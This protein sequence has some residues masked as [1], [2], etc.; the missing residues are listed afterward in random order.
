MDLKLE[1]VLVWKAKI[2]KDISIDMHQD[3][4][5]SQND[6]LVKKFSIQCSN[7]GQ[8]NCRLMFCIKKPNNGFFV[9]C[10]LVYPD[11]MCQLAQ[12]LSNSKLEFEKN[13]T[14][15][16]HLFSMEDLK[17]MEKK[18]PKFQS[19]LIVEIPPETFRT[20]EIIH[21]SNCEIVKNST[22]YI[23]LI[24]I[25]NKVR[26]ANCLSMIDIILTFKNE[27]TAKETLIYDPPT[28]KDFVL[29]S[30]KI[31]NDGQRMFSKIS[32]KDDSEK[33]SENRY[34]EYLAELLNKKYEEIS[35][36]KNSRA[37]I[38]IPYVEPG[39]KVS[40]C[41]TYSNLMNMVTKDNMNSFYL[42][43][44]HMFFKHKHSNLKKFLSEVKLSCSSSIKD[45]KVSWDHE[46]LA[47]SESSEKEELFFSL[48][49]APTKFTEFQTKFSSAIFNRSTVLI[50]KYQD[51]HAG[52]VFFDPNLEIEE[53]PITREYIFV[54][55]RSGS[56]WGEK[57]A[58]A[59]RA[60]KL[61]L[62]SLGENSTFNIVSF[63]SNAVL[64][65]PDG[66]LSYNDKNKTMAFDALDTFTADMEG[67]NIFSALTIIY[68]QKIKPDTLRFIFF[69]TD[70]EDSTKDQSLKLIEDNK[71]KTRVCTIGIFA[72]SES[73]QFLEGAA[74]NGNG[75]CMNIE[76]IEDI[77]KKLIDQL[78]FFEKKEINELKINLTNDYYDCVPPNLS[79]QITDYKEHT[80]YFVCKE[81]NKQVKI[82]FK[83]EYL[84]KDRTLSPFILK[85]KE[86]VRLDKIF[87]EK[88]I[89]YLEEC[90]KS[91][92]IPKSNVKN[93][94]GNLFNLKNIPIT[95]KKKL[96]NEIK[97]CSEKYQVTSKRTNLDFEIKSITKDKNSEHKEPMNEVQENLS[98]FRQ[99][100]TKLPK[101]GF[102]KK[103]DEVKIE[104]AKMAE[105]PSK[106]I[107]AK[108]VYKKDFSNKA[109]INQS[110]KLNKK[111]EEEKKE[112]YESDN[113]TG[114]ESVGNKEAKENEKIDSS[115][116]N[117]ESE[118]S[119][120]SEESENS[121]E[122]LE[123][124]KEE[125]AP[126][127]KLV[128]ELPEEYKLLTRKVLQITEQLDEVL[129]LFGKSSYVLWKDTIILFPALLL[130]TSRLPKFSITK[131]MTATIFILG[132]FEIQYPELQAEWQKEYDLGIDWLKYHKFIYSSNHETITEIIT[133]IYSTTTYFPDLRSENLIIKSNFEL[134]LLLLKLHNGLY[135]SYHIISTILPSIEKFKFNIDYENLNI[136]STVYILA[137]LKK[138][139]AEFECD[140]KFMYFLSKKWLESFFID[141]DKEISWIVGVSYIE[142][143]KEKNEIGLEGEFSETNFNQIIKIFHTEGYWD[144][145]KTNEK[146]SQLA[147]LLIM[148]KDNF[149]EDVL[150]TLFIVNI[151]ETK[152]SDKE[153][154]WRI[155]KKKAENWLKKENAQLKESENLFEGF[156]SVFSYR[157]IQSQLVLNRYWHFILI[158][159][160]SNG[161]YWE[162]NVGSQLFSSLGLYYYA[163]CQGLD[164]DIFTTVVFIKY[165]EEYYSEELLEWIGF[166]KK[167]IKWLKTEKGINYQVIKFEFNCPE[168]L[169]VP[170]MIS[171]NEALLSSEAI[172]AKI[173]FDHCKY[174]YATIIISDCSTYFEVITI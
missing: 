31:N 25:K 26:I 113:F 21:A 7:S 140:W 134:I 81:F 143:G 17:K 57:L 173:M 61:C 159:S 10:G 11:K 166:I 136:K 43:Y 87:G 5:K 55:D 76:K 66:S 46:M 99:L 146:F 122:S 161:V 58:L 16:Q 8:I 124:N 114:N 164:Q 12:V 157:L 98:I 63:G 1:D 51:M 149:K 15:C 125:E 100:L 28:N 105:E 20:I 3:A 24:K 72:S 101:S 104:E 145:Q 60:L 108:I 77:S 112:T 53:K 171:I 116:S 167:A 67:T 103:S 109:I 93:A 128:K 68:E 95:D 40:I 29:V 169:R 123:I 32:S 27:S 49:K 37:K 75:I 48:K 59:S 23:S 160:V 91:I 119:D 47:K 135:W 130:F 151:L 41:F 138:F 84:K 131:D 90:I 142:M 64:F 38:C 162:F 14:G 126:Q 18:Q 170:N 102:A 9:A 83:D 39:K 94:S 158:L 30:I 153:F 96:I 172:T 118:S 56:M 6:Y 73:M 69:I 65:A 133:S 132:L 86:D 4:P 155:I 156:R 44:S 82:T 152:Y 89:Q 79:K 121:E 129:K 168:I 22:P 74:K 106:S 163:K 34:K 42:S 35:H 165:L 174:E 115:E 71:I 80:I 70:G 52:I 141:A 36:M 13:K 97:L 88:K 110:K 50:Q 85:I 19:V 78:D 120:E 150:A 54:L 107:T 117:E 139:F 62:S 147:S 33:L 127:K 2:P 92:S 148:H 111:N 154:E 144:F 137:I 45:V